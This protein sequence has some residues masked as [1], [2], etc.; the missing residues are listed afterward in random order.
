M[1]NFLMLCYFLVSSTAFGM[2][3]T[4]DS[5]IESTVQPLEAQ[6]FV[7]EK[8]WPE[9][10][11]LSGVESNGEYTIDLNCTKAGSRKKSF[12][13]TYQADSNEGARCRDTIAQSI[14]QK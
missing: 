8:K 3:Y 7:C 10:F 2:K 4:D 6:G 9:N 14:R 5:A 13:V 1:K 11:Y 12:V